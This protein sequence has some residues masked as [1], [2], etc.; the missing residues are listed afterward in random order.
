[1]ATY[2]SEEFMNYDEF[3]PKKGTTVPVLREMINRCLED[4]L[5]CVDGYYGRYAD[6][7]AE[8]MHKY[9]DILEK[10]T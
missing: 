4:I 10:N 6:M 3:K 5:G 1:M 8:E 7:K 2:D 9:L